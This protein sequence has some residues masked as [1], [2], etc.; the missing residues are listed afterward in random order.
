[1]GTRVDLLVPLDKSARVQ[2]MVDSPVLAGPESQK[3][4]SLVMSFAYAVICFSMPTL[5]SLWHFFG[6]S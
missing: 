5:V 1:M 3:I 6:L 4:D 2:A